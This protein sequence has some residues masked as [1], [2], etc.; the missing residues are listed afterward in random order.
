[1][2]VLFSIWTLAR[3]KVQGQ[4]HVALAQ[5]QAKGCRWHQEHLPNNYKLLRKE[6]RGAKKY[7]RHFLSLSLVTTSTSPDHSLRECILMCI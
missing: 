7:K 3:L 2:K 6:S 5:G 4:G 1:M